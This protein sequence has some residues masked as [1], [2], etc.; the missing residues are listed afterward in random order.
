[1]TA[2]ISDT[3]DITLYI[4]AL[5]E[6]ITE[7]NSDPEYV[8]DYRRAQ[9]YQVQGLFA[10]SLICLERA[11][12]DARPFKYDF[13]WERTFLSIGTLFASNLDYFDKLDE[14]EDVYSELLRSHPDGDFL[15]D[16]AIFLHKRRRDYNK[17]EMLVLEVARP[18]SSQ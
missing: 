3:E 8:K 12:T 1:M 10:E 11:M 5:E 14:A 9:L 18:N 15:C 13:I 16:Y 4:S 17:A 7:N 2:S 6:R